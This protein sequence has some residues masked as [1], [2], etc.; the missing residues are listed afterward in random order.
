MRSNNQSNDFSRAEPTNSPLRD[1][2]KWS[3]S[4]KTPS[5]SCGHLHVAGRSKKKKKKNYSAAPRNAVTFYL[6]T[7]VRE[8]DTST[9][10]S[11]A[12][13]NYLKKDMN[14]KIYNA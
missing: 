13:L 2:N 8:A 6:Q 1:S 7:I 3:L 5:P 9:T 12:L 4:M 11:F 14:Q 10:G